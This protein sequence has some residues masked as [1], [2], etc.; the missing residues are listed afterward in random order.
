MQDAD[1]ADPLRVVKNL[2]RMSAACDRAEADQLSTILVFTV[3]A[4]VAVALA[5]VA[6][7]VWYWEQW[8]SHTAS[9]YFTLFDR[10]SSGRVT[11]E[12]LYTGVL[13]LYAAVPMKVYPPQ[14]KTVHKILSYLEETRL[15]AQSDS[16]DV[17]EF[18]L[19]MA[20]LSAQCLS[21]L[22]ITFLY[23]LSC[24][25]MGGVLWTIVD[26][27]LL[28]DASQ[29]E[30]QFDVRAGVPRLVKCG[31]S[32]LNQLHLGPPLLTVV[33]MLPSKRVVRAG[34]KCLKG[35]ALLVHYWCR[36]GPRGDA[37]APAGGD[38][39]QADAVEKT[40]EQLLATKQRI[41]GNIRRQSVMAPLLTPGLSNEFAPEPRDSRAPAEGDD[42][43]DD[44]ALHDDVAGA[45]IA[46]ARQMSMSRSQ[47]HRGSL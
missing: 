46:L 4:F 2:T 32:V 26:A 35:V 7:L 16:L 40:K 23:Y 19:V 47:I 22:V 20:T 3:A 15:I 28:D 37:S 14:R 10:D 21:R 33:L 30:L 11:R 38:G 45:A 9:K 17:E 36:A 42:D 24:P 18:S 8:Y 39:Q 25:V 1:D 29:E 12:E 41:A 31:G 43:D 44:E 27:Y 13:Q 5:G 6:W 34:E